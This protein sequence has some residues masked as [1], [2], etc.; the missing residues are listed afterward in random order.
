VLPINLDFY[1][2]LALIA[3]LAVELT[4]VLPDR[5]EVLAGLPRARRRFVVGC[6][7]PSQIQRAP[8]PQAQS[9]PCSSL[10][11]VQADRAFII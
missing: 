3:E 7:W 11:V 5:P 6:G 10:I 4:T 2:P 8:W 1:A 9:S